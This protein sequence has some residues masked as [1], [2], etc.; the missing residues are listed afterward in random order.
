M[1]RSIKYGLVFSCCW[2]SFLPGLGVS[3]TIRVGRQ[4]TANAVAAGTLQVSVSPA[5]VTFNLVSNG[6]ATG[7]GAV[8]VTTAW[9]V[10]L[11]LVACSIKLYGYFS[12]ANSALSGGSP[13]VNIA[14]SSV[15]GQ[16]PTGAPTSFTPF[17]QSA[18]FGGAGA[19]LLLFNQAFTLL[20]L[21]GSR[22]DSLSLEIN[23][24]NQPQLPAGTYTGTLFIQAQV[25]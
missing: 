1:C 11:C 21:A 22:T 3:Q 7:S 2:V 12:S 20:T 25:L 19:S 23:L 10:N 17:T 9:G 18:P 15:L 5:S 16:V 24:A 13:V 8:A 14:S 4:I 6:V